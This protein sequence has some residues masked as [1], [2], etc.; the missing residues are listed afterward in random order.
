MGRRQRVVLLVPILIADGL[1]F[2]IAAVATGGSGALTVLGGLSSRTIFKSRGEPD[3]HAGSRETQ[4]G[5]KQLVF[6]RR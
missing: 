3:R 1:R 6:A 4:H 5:R 2:S